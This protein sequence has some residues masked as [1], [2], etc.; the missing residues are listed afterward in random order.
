MCPSLALRA[1]YDYLIQSRTERQRAKANMF[2]TTVETECKVTSNVSLDSATSQSIGVKLGISWTYT[3]AGSDTKYGISILTTK[4]TPSFC[5]TAIL[6]CPT[7]PGSQAEQRL[8]RE[9]VSSLFCFWQ[10]WKYGINASQWKVHLLH[11]P[12]GTAASSLTSLN[13]LPSKGHLSQ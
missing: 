5:R 1:I 4:Y 10:T 6:H 3:K 12:K 9:T 8:V 2:P 13:F 11:V 7:I